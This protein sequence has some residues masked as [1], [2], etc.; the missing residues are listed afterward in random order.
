MKPRS[1]ARVEVIENGHPKMWLD[2]LKL[3]PSE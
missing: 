2:Y 1:V 3:H